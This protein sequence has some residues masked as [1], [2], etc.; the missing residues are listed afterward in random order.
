MTRPCP[1]DPR[2]HE[3]ARVSIPVSITIYGSLYDRPIAA[4]RLIPYFARS[5]ID[6]P[7]LDSLLN[8]SLEHLR[9]LEDTTIE[10]TDDFF[11][12]DPP[13]PAVPLE[14]DDED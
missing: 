10:D 9:E 11:P 7:P 5:H 3:P 14:S 4:F 12:D 6:L 13:L 2:T 1:R 8:I